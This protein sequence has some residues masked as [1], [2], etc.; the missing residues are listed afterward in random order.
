MPS[1]KSEVSKKAKQADDASSHLVSG[2]FEEIAMNHFSIGD[3]QQWCS[4]PE[5][6][7]EFS[8]K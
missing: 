7:A 4:R 6:E 5:D 1:E 2:L 8:F 3:V